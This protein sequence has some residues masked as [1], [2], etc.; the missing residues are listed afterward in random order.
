[1][2]GNNFFNP[3]MYQ[4]YSTAANLNS[5]GGLGKAASGVSSSNIGLKGILGKFNFTNFLDGASKTL[6]VVN[7]AI[8]V[9]YQVKP[10]INNARTMF[11]I[12]GAVKSPDTNTNKGTTQNINRKQNNDVIST[13]LTN[14]SN[15]YNYENPT[16]FI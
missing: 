11:R 3:Y 10:V 13:T 4:S 1:M 9:F 5:L 6:N 2:F 15:D 16:F 7:Q 8:P 14:N 12:L